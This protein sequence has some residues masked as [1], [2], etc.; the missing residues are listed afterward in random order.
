LNVISLYVNTTKNDIS[1]FLLEKKIITVQMES[2][3]IRP[4]KLTNLHKFTNQISN[5]SKSMESSN[6]SKLEESK[7][8]EH[9]KTEHQPI[10]GA[11]SHQSNS[12]GSGKCY[13]CNRKVGLLGFKCRCGNIFCSGH[14][15]C[16]DHNCPIDYKQLHR[17]KIKKENPKVENSKIVPI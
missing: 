16:E 15:H 13:K 12:P 11:N 1:F 5:E 10:S 9:L 7:S 8:R 17:E 4:E 14:R 6:K 3:N 2:Q